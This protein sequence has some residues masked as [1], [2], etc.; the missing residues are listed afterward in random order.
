[1]MRKIINKCVCLGR[2]VLDNF[3]T[4]SVTNKR[5]HVF[6]IWRLHSQL[7]KRD[8]IGYRKVYIFI[9]IFKIIFIF[10]FLK[11]RFHFFKVVRYLIDDGLRNLNGYNSL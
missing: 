2:V 11:S 7:H 4:Q 9:Y 6:I 1:M 10:I 8:S 5:T 3:Y